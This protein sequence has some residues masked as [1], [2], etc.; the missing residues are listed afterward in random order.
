MRA[1]PTT[2]SSALPTRERLVIAA[3]ELF[4]ARGYNATSL[5]DICAR[6]ESNPG[7]LYHFFT[8]KQDLLE[9]VLERL[10]ERIGPDLLEPAWDGVDDPIERVFA[11]LGAYRRALVATDFTYGCPIG[12][13]ALELRDPPEE[14]RRRIAANFE[15]WRYA[16]LDCLEKARERFRAGTDLGRLAT[17]V[18]TVMEGGVM[19][20]RTFRTVEPFDAG[21]GF[22]R[23]HIETLERTATQEGV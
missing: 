11:L 12:G 8:T 9:A 10:E 14:V 18:L 1:G 20:A 13:L 5:A 16:V 4:W 22:L 6:A 2:R 23:E 7:S 21:V 17:V 19:Q 15:A 3:T